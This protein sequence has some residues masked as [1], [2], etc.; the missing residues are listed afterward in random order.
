MF[1]T[2]LVLIACVP[3]LLRDGSAKSDLDPDG[4]ANCWPGLS[5]SAQPVNRKAGLELEG[6][7]DSLW[8][9]IRHGFTFPPVLRPGVIT[10]ID[11]LVERRQTLNN[12][13]EQAIP[14]LY[15]I[16]EE[17]EKRG[18]PMELVFIPA[19]ESAYQGS[20]TGPGGTAGM[21]QFTYG[22]GQ[23]LG[24]R[25]NR[26]LDERRDVLSSTEAALD[27][28]QNL[29]EQFHGD[30]EL[31]VAAYNAGP[32]VVRNAINKNR[33]HGKATDFWSLSLP[34]HTRQYIPQIY[35]YAAVVSD[36][37]S[38]DISLV[39]IPNLPLCATVEFDHPVSL[40]QASQASGASMNILKRLNPALKQGHTSPT[41]PHRLLV[42]AGLASGLASGLKAEE[43]TFTLAESTEPRLNPPQPTDS[44]SPAKIHLVQSGDSLSRIASRYHVSAAAIR[45]LNGA[46]AHRLRPGTV[47]KIP[48]KG[49]AAS[50]DATRKTTSSRAEK[51]QRP[52]ASSRSSM[53]SRSSS[54]ATRSKAKKTKS[55]SASSSA[56]PNRLTR[57]P[58]SAKSTQSHKPVAG[59]LHK[60][61]PKSSSKPRPITRH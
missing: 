23:T 20:A 49:E 41:G 24:L 54:H 53:S 13:F 25:N 14:Y 58:K 34:G 61:A 35:A 5:G 29:G 50:L 9:R 2:V 31:A 39:E 46:A 27:Y 40:H 43:P 57:L 32:L 44:S 28:L 55:R 48:P 51:G 1:S 8:E 36:P 26:W 17:I 15:F 56:S 18:L 42:P 3:P 10:A 59:L 33:R 11:T 12:V 21:W 45:R 22:T 7:S 16:V 19:I 60:K 4:W 52:I 47:L 37:K 30:W 6:E 38:F